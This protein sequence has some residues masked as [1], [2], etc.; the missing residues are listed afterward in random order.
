[1]LDQRITDTQSIKIIPYYGT[2]KVIQLQSFQALGVVDLDR[3][4]GGLN[5]R[6][7][8]S[9][10]IAEHDLN[11]TAGLDYDKMVETRKAFNNNNGVVDSA[12]QRNE[13]D[14]VY[15]L[16]PYVQ[17]QLKLTDKWDVSGGLRYNNVNF[18]ID[19][20]FNAVGSANYNSGSVSYSETTPSMGIVYHATPSINLY[21]NA[22]KG[23]E[24]PTFA[25]I[26][27]SLNTNGTVNTSK[28][29]L[30]LKPAKSTT[31]EIGAKTF[32]ADNS[33]LNVAA[34]T[35]EV[36]DEIAAANNSGGKVAYQNIPKTQRNGLEISLDSK[37]A[38]GLQT[39]AS[40]TFLDA[41]VDQSYSKR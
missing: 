18:R 34:F 27:Y 7:N 22:G 39:Y 41:Y 6:Y 28:S 5:L 31:Y 4:F 38:Y 19:D 16:D 17:A 20:K 36:S 12:I 23:F 15:N 13:D 29:T 9:G 35:T 30:L 40:Y 32:L 37:W 33:Q 25:E 10:K 21:A 8:Y 3:E 26:S 11:I 24:T 2:R 1:V 14:S